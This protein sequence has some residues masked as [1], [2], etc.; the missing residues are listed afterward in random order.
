ALPVDGKPPAWI[1][2]DGVMIDAPSLNATRTHLG[3]SSQAPD[4]AAEPFSSAL[5]R[6][7]P[8]Q[9]AK[10]QDLPAATY[11]RSEVW[12]WKSRDGRDVEG[13]VT[14]PSGDAAGRKVPLVVVVH[15]GPAGVV[16]Q[17][18]TGTLTTYSVGGFGARGLAVLRVNPRGSSGYGAEFRGANYR[19]WGGGDY[20]DIMS[21]VDALVA[22]GVADP[23]RL[24]IMGWSYGGF[25]TSWVITPTPR[26]KAG[27]VRGGGADQ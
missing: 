18:F 20:E 14:Y 23:D 3:F 6:F 17:A 9:A 21:G 10:V 16:T 25:M 4:R 8:V 2:P 12:S 5:A 27:S 24:G 26:F 1:S 19:D 22:K 15:G 13:L 11:G 7:A